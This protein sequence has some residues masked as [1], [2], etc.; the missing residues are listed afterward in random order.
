MTAGLRNLLPLVV[1][2]SL[3]CTQGSPQSTLA[4]QPQRLVVAIQ[5]TLAASE[6][7]EKAKPLEQYLEEHVSG[8]DVEV[9]VPLSQAGVIEAIRFGQADVAF[10]GAW[11]ALLAVTKADAELVLAEVREVVH[12][13]RKMEET[14]YFSYWIAPTGSPY[15]SLEQ[16]R[17]RTACFPSPISGSGYV[18]PMGR[19]VE[20][21]LF[22]KTSG[23]RSWRF[24]SEVTLGAGTP[25]A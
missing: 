18:G 5:P 20:L 15:T 12:N 8:V 1:L 6:M 22:D 24:F 17:G 4:S 23:G 9:Y 14:Y 2:L 3:A 16:S 13:D 19:L 7:L 10:M 11:P 25:N 21:G